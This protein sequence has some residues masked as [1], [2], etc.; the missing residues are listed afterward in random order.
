MPSHAV[1]TN[2]TFQPES[3]A[4]RFATSISKP[5]RSPCLLRIAQGTKVDIPT[6]SEPRSLILS[7]LGVSEAKV[8]K[9]TANAKSAVM[10]DLN[11]FMLI[12]PY[13]VRQLAPSLCSSQAAMA[14]SERVNAR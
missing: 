2:S 14:E 5:T 7:R 4:R 3:S 10:A 8:G 9:L 13:C 11:S 12:F 1:G 6:R